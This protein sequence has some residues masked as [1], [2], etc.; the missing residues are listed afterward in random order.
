MAV[1]KIHSLDRA[2]ELVF[3]SYR[4]LPARFSETFE[5][6]SALQAEVA[7]GWV[8]G[9]VRLGR[10]PVVDFPFELHSMSPDARDERR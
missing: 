8:A 9:Q 6:A 1:L 5:T 10:G 7:D 2:R 4:G 3:E